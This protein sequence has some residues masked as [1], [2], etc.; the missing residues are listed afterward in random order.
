MTDSA[1]AP[2]N[3]VRS[4]LRYSPAGWIDAALQRLS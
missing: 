3:S 1:V 2:S 4:A